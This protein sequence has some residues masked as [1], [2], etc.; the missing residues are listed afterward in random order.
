M[1]RLMNI[2]SGSKGNATYVGNDHTHI[3]IDSGVSRKRIL[4]GLKKLDLTLQDLSAIL[5]THE[6]SDHIS[7][8]GVLERTREIPVYTA[9]GTAKALINSGTLGSQSGLVQVIEPGRPFTIGDL[10]VTGLATSHDAADPV[11][12][13]VDQGSTSCAVVTDLGVYDSRLVEELQGLSALILE[14]NHDIRMLE[15]GPY[16]Y[17]VKLRIAGQK[18]HLS[19]ET[20]G[21]LLAELLNDDL[22][23]VALGHLSPCN[24]TPDLALLSVE[25]ELCRFAE[26]RC[27]DRF[28]L[29]VADQEKGS[30]IFEF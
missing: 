6:H 13:R 7:S 15:T 22:Q 4:E 10:T 24:N 2:A 25:Y 14:A 23:Y 30:A 17:P 27:M 28:R 12:Y 8:L 20:S 16:P 1:M 9:G 26:P 29:D 3:L 11:C 21:R 5:V 19:N 18:G